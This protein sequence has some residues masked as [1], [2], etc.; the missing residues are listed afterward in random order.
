MSGLEVLLLV[1]VAY[2]GGRA[3]QRWISRHER[4]TAEG[5]RHIVDA[6]RNQGKGN[7]E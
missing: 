7:K 2:Y 6:M 4:K 1:G 5:L 3:R